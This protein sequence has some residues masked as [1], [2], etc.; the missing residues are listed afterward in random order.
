[1]QGH[2]V[3]KISLQSAPHIF[4]DQKSF[5]VPAITVGAAISRWISF[6]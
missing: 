2:E 6:H 3:T 4:Y 1:M 5:F